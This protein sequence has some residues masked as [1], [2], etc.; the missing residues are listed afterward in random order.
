MTR[1]ELILI[2]EMLEIVSIW[3]TKFLYALF[4]VCK[5][6]QM[7]SFI[8]HWIIWIF[9]FVPRSF[10]TSVLS[11]ITRII[12]LLLFILDSILVASCISGELIY[13][14]KVIQIIPPFL[15]LLKLVPWH[16]WNVVR[17]I[18]PLLMPTFRNLFWDWM[19]MLN[20]LNVYLPLKISIVSRN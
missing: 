9:A 18:Y 16:I 19:N 11:H 20:I 5:R 12:V 6:G 14:L 3:P 10:K 7:H 1:P 15:I 17:R 13:Y 2:K 4:A 8:A